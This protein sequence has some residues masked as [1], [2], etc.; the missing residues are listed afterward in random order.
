[1]KESTRKKLDR[2]RGKA[3]ELQRRI[4]QDTQDRKALLRQISEIE[5]AEIFSIIRKNGLPLEVVIGDLEFGQQMR[6]FGVTQEDIKELFTPPSSGTDAAVD[7]NS[8]TEQEERT[9]L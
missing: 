5:N 7:A 2:L 6:A 3:D 9:I 1:M 4:Q 8:S